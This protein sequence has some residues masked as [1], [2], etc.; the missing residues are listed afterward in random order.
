MTSKTMKAG[1]ALEKWKLPIFKRLLDQAG[2]T[3]TE[4][5]GLTPDAAWLKVDVSAERMQTLQT[6]IRNAQHEC[7]ASKG[8]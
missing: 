7:R 2:F 4:H 5:N 1:V 8:N 3:Y 6:V